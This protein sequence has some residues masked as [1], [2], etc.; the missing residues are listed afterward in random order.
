[1][2]LPT[3]VFLL[4][5]DKSAF[6]LWRIHKTHLAT[7]GH[8]ADWAHKVIL[9]LNN[10]YQVYMQNTDVYYSLHFEGFSCYIHFTKSDIL[11][12]FLACLCMKLINWN[13][14]TSVLLI[15]STWV[16]FLTDYG[17]L[18]LSGW[19]GFNQWNGH[20]KICYCKDLSHHGHIFGQKSQDSQNYFFFPRR[21][22]WRGE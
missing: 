15:L 17:L 2:Q 6:M 8:L 4:Q 21:L 7:K 9:A 1:M 12:P 13:K 14:Y 5:G 11:T 22:G 19:I 18:C 10:F 3:H 16:A 20:I